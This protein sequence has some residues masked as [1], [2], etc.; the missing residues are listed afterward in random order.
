MRS[1]NGDLRIKLK[2]L[3]SQRRRFGYRCL[4]LLLARQ[5]VG[6]NHKNFYRLYKED[7]N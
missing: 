1:V 7:R 4:G 6:I 2:E 5:G 3:T